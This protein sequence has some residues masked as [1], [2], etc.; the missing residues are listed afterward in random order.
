MLIVNCLLPSLHSRGRP[1]RVPQSN[2]KDRQK[3]AVTLSEGCDQRHR[4]IIPQPQRRPSMG[5]QPQVPPPQHIGTRGGIRRRRGYP[6]DHHRRGPHCPS[7]VAAVTC[8]TSLIIALHNAT[9]ARGSP[10]SRRPPRSISRR[11]LRHRSTEVQ[12]LCE[13]GSHTTPLRVP[14]TQLPP[15][16]AVGR[17]VNPECSPVPL[18]SI[19]SGKQLFAAPAWQEEAAKKAGRSGWRATRGSG[20]NMPLILEQER[21][22]DWRED[23]FHHLPQSTVL[24]CYYVAGM[25]K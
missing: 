22:P 15:Q 5:A 18:P 9:A 23:A 7:A 14:L 10:R 6:G 13:H 16:V 11:Q 20:A 12:P 1:G 19:P 2:V 8:C 3:A 25:E 4:E 21:G 17:I 24:E